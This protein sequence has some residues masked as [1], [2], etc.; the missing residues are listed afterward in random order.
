VNHPTAQVLEGPG[1]V[2]ALVL[3]GPPASG[4]TTVRSIMSDYGA[5][6]CDV[7]DCYSGGQLVDHSWADRVEGIA[8][9]A[10]E[11]RPQVCAIEGLL[12][13]DHVDR[14][15]DLVGDVLVIRVAAPSRE[16]RIDRFVERELPDRK[17]GEAVE[18]DVLTK[19]RTTADRRYHEETPYPQH[20]V[21]IIN[22][23]DVKASELAERVANLVS[24]VSDVDRD[25]FTSPKATVEGEL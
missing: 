12:E 18:V 5:V 3:V 22:A 7:A 8:L 25:E 13:D 24:A 9:K 19:L 6:G 16:D 15:R 23:D 17:D 14:V 11:D 10:S 21:K 20:D 1:E 4:K 2:T